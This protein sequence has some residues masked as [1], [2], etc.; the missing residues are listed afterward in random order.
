M[1]DDWQL[2]M[3]TVVFAATALIGGLMYMDQR[4]RHDTALLLRS[5]AISQAHASPKMAPH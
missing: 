4:N 2:A 5:V 1:N 3:M